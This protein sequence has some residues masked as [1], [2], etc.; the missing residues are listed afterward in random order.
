MDFEQLTIE[1]KAI[2]ITATEMLNDPIYEGNEAMGY[3]TLLEICE[4]QEERETASYVWGVGIGAKGMAEKLMPLIPE[5]L[6]P[7]T[8]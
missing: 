8:L 4:S 5:E 1:Q 6:R 3:R 7:E 2:Y